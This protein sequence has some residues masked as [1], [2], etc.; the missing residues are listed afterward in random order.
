MLFSYGTAGTIY[1]CQWV[2]DGQVWRLVGGQ[3]V[4]CTPRPGEPPPPPPGEYDP[5]ALPFEEDDTALEEPALAI[6][7]RG[8][9]CAPPAPITLRSAD[10]T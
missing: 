10:G 3:M 4:G 6:T 7:E 9:T 5:W 2:V 8:W 1:D